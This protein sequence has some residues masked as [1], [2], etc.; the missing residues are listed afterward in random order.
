MKSIIAGLAIAAGMTI[1]GSSTAIDMPPLAIKDNCVACHAI[2]KKVVGPAWM[3]VS[4][5]Y[6]DATTYTYRGKVYPLLDGL[7]L[8][9][10]RGGAGNWGSMPM[11]G[12]SPAVSESDIREIVKFELGLA[13]SPSK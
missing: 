8:K 12:N 5:R 4:K 11:P 6:K 13:K 3:D 9:V 2:D 7:V 1:A 10:E